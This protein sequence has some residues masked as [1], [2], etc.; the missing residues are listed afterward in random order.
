MGQIYH[1]AAAPD[2]EE[3]KR[4]GEYRISTRGKT[5]DEVGFIH[6]GDAHQVA[7]V[8]NAIYG[9]D[10]NLVVLVI[11]CARVKSEIRYDPVRGWEDP[12]PHIYGPLNLDA[13]VRTLVLE[14][15]TT[16]L[17]SFRASEK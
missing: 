5:L 11:D 10:E 7:P 1:I 13:V 9:D 2:W 8:A 14:R 17:F 3:A 12:F 6:A 15:D 4:A 16:G